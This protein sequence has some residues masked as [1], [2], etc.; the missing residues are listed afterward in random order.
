MDCRKM[1]GW[2]YVALT[3]EVRRE[4]FDGVRD[5]V[6]RR[7]RFPFLFSHFHPS[8]W[9]SPEVKCIITGSAFAEEQGKMEEVTYLP[10]TQV[11]GV[12]RHA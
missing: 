8:N 10:E 12:I 5:D 9:K 11:F 2:H 4:P 1:R 3:R 7:T 6:P